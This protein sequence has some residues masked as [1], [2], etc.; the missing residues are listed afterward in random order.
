MNLYPWG[1][2]VLGFC[3]GGAVMKV[4]RERRDRK[5]IAALDSLLTAIEHEDRVD[6]PPR[7]LALAVG[8]AREVLGR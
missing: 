6:S 2:L 3:I 5:L 1:M 4:I 8:F 7:R